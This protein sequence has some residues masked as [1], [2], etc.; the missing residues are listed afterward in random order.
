MRNLVVIGLIATLLTASVAR[1]DLEKGKL[2]PDIE[3][4]EWLNTQKP[5]SLA[6]LRGMVVV[7]YFWVSFHEGGQ[8]VLPLMTLADG[9]DL[10]GRKAGV[11]IM[12]VTDAD[13]KRMEEQVRKAKIFFPIALE[14]KS[15]DEYEIESFPRAVILDTDGKIAWTGWP[16]EGGGDAMLQAI[17]DVIEESPPTRTHPREAAVCYE[18]LDSAKGAIATGDYRSAYVSARQANEHALAGDPLKARCQDYLDLL[19]AIGQ[20]LLANGEREIVTNEFTAGVNYFDR[21]AR[22]FRGMECGR[23]ARKRLLALAKEHDEVQSILDRQEEETLAY[24]DLYESIE[25]IKRQQFASAY[26]RLNAMVKERGQT[27]ASKDARVLMDRIQGHK[28]VWRLV[29]D[30][31]AAS[32]AEPML[33]EARSAIRRKRF[34]EAQR[35]LRKIMDQHPDTQYASKAREMLIELP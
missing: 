21:A 5:V 28:D 33:S 30:H 13:R 12:G 4:K 22:E 35:I 25:A 31:M 20:D 2:A 29:R 26:E 6:E 32:D 23:Q 15:D 27:D 18:L 9:S 8:S 10:A 17:L 34:S 19:E 3:A 7:L 14:S 24:R 16:G 1:A 11:Y